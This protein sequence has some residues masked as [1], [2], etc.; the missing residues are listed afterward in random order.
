MLKCLYSIKQLLLTVQFIQQLTIA[1]L[2][3]KIQ[4]A[5]NSY[6]SKVYW[7]IGILKKWNVSNQ[8]HQNIFQYKACYFIIGRYTQLTIISKGL[9]SALLGGGCIR[10]NYSMYKCWMLVFN[11]LWGYSLVN[12]FDI[13]Y[14]ARDSFMCCLCC[15][16]LLFFGRLT[17]YLLSCVLRVCVCVL[18]SKLGARI[19]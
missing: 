7:N 19:T 4:V 14:L 18:N 16:F 11:Y 8:E 15:Y 13:L 12:L 17:Y 10:Y 2:S 9:K 5:L 3:L 1:N 6:P